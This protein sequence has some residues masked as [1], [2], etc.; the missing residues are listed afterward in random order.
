[1]AGALTAY[2]LLTHPAG[3]DPFLT[4]SS[5]C[6]TIP[7]ESGQNSTED[8]KNFQEENRVTDSGGTIGERGKLMLTAL[9]KEYARQAP[10]A[11]SEP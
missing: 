8:R 3:S 6:W 2:F 9:S 5:I 1:M 7:S 11:E 4:I 10:D